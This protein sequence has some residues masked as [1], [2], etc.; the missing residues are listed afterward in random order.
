MRSVCGEFALCS[1]RKSLGVV[2]LP[3]RTEKNMDKAAWERFGAVD[4]GMGLLTSPFFSHLHDLFDSDSLY[5]PD[6]NKFQKRSA[7]KQLQITAGAFCFGFI[8]LLHEV[9][10]ALHVEQ[11]ARE[12]LNEIELDGE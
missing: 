7:V 4:Y 11:P 10:Q 5:S 2:K 9:F 12:R 8:L 6:D 3:V 1:E